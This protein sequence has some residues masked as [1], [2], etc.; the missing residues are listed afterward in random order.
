MPHPYEALT[1]RRVSPH[2]GAEIADIDITRPLS[3]HVVDELHHALGEFGVL[4]F[5]DQRFDHDSQKRFGRYFGALDIHPNTPGPDGHPEILPIHADASSKVIAGERWHSDVSCFQEPPLGSILHIHTT[6]PY[7]GDTLFASLA[8]AYDALSPRL[9]AYLEGLTATHSGERNYRRRNALTGV[10]DDGRVFPKAVHPVVIRHPISGRRGLYVNRLFTLKINEVSE[11][12]S[13][14]ILGHLY[15]HAERPDFQ[16][17][18]QW[19]PNSVAFWDNRAVQHLAIWDY[20]P[21]T[22]SGSRVTVKGERLFA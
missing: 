1:I 19:Q 5:R 18:F 7:G 21:H 17:R 14:A 11:E 13:E 22:R 2:V 6:P 16:I 9:Q 8:A 20:F 3:N 12:E 4:V 10:N 15:S